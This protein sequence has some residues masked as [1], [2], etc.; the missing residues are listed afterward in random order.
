MRQPHTAHLCWAD[1][2]GLGGHELL[3]AIDRSD[4]VGKLGTVSSSVLGKSRDKTETI[5]RDPFLEKVVSG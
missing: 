3:S 1:L 4:L 2:V 5:Q